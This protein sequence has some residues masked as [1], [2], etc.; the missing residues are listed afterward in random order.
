MSFEPTTI[1]QA[2]EW[3]KEHGGKALYPGFPFFFVP[4]L[5]ASII[6]GQFSGSLTHY[7]ND[8]PAALELPVRFS[9]A[10]TKQSKATL[11]VVPANADFFLRNSGSGIESVLLSV[12]LSKMKSNSERVTLNKEGLGMAT[13]RGV[14]YPMVII[15]EGEHEAEIDPLG[16][17][18]QVLPKL[19]L[20]TALSNWM[21]FFLLGGAVFGFGVSTGFLNDGAIV[22]NKEP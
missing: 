19:E 11:L 12:E 16:K 7:P 18:P 8:R 20:T 1:K 13:L 14:G 17:K 6:W 2:L 10:S 5:L 15:V 9:Q 22:N 21:V 4:A 3:A